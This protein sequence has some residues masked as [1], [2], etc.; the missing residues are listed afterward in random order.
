MKKYILPLYLI[1]SL[2]MF[3]ACDHID[4]SE[5]LIHVPMQ[6]AKRV[7]LL[8]DFTGQQ[9]VNCPTGSEV[10]EQLLKAYPDNVI[11]VGIHSGPLGFKGNSNNIGL[12]TELGDEYYYHW[13]LEYQPVGLIDRHGAV[14]YTDWTKEV[15][16]ELQ[17]ESSLEMDLSATISDDQII[18]T[19]NETALSAGINGKIQVW[20]LED[21]ITASQ[22]MPGG[23]VNK[24][25]VHNHVLRAAV[26]GTWGEGCAPKEG[27]TLTQTYSQA[28]D[29]AWD[30]ANLSIVAFVYDDSGVLQAVKTKVTYSLT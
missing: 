25:Y 26:N 2:M 19:V 10:I 30:T 16:E 20:L 27:E 9:C 13:D 18:I 5:R 11:A 7:V 17:K 24:E 1:A 29:A 3:V 6:P 15:E 23:S 28:I 21:G 4:E 22:K 8:E 14:N 12:A